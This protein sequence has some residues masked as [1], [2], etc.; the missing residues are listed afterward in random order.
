MKTYISLLR[1]INV[2]GQKK[3]R[4]EELRSLFESLGF[5]EVRS[6]VQ[7][8]N[9]IFTSDLPDGAQIARLIEERIE[10]TFGFKAPVLVR[11]PADFARI[12]DSNPFIS[13]GESDHK[14]H[15]VVFLYSPPTWEALGSLENPNGA[16][17]AFAPG[18]QEIFL[19][20]PGG[21]G[22][23]KLDNNFFERKL[24][25]TATTRNWKTVKT[26]YEMAVG[27]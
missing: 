18:A 4:M 24:G 20:T 7:S 17:D 25:V 16:G 12:V 10:E 8:G 22:K 26:L 5:G 11:E 19:H 1:G 27:E 14:G 9:V 15:Y 23:T 6:Y 13:T 2:S 21:F 3:I